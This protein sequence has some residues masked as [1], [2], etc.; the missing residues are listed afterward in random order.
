V[1]NI[2]VATGNG[3]KLE[4]IQQILGDSY[5]VK[6]L[7]DLRQPIDIVE[8]GNTYYENALK[9]AQTLFELVR[10]PVFADD[11]GLEVDALDGAPGIFS[12]RFAGEEG[13]HQ[14]YS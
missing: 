6:G 14:K 4:E 7:K 8:D 1:K 12:A 13:N 2:W 10:E 3:H 5:R 11:S 9:K